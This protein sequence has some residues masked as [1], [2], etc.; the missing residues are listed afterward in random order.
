[1]KYIVEDHV[2]ITTLPS[3]FTTIRYIP[4]ARLHAFLSTFDSLLSYVFMMVLETN[5]PSI[6]KVV[7]MDMNIIEFKHVKF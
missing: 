6:V 4:C 1:V 3:R 2:L 7:F 5:L